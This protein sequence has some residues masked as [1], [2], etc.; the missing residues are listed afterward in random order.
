MT[1]DN[2][3]KRRFRLDLSLIFIA[4]SIAYLIYQDSGSATSTTAL[5]ILGPAGAGLLA[6]YIFGAVWD[7]KVYMDGVKTM[8]NKQQEHNYDGGF[9]QF[10]ESPE[11][12][13]Y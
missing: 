12:R 9:Y 5:T 7:Y 4:L 3:G 1:R 10:N 6:S 13:E 2:W 11:T 8:N